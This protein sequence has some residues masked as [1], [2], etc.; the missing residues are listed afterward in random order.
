MVTEELPIFGSKKVTDKF[1]RTVFGPVFSHSGVV[2]CNCDNCLQK[3][4]NRINDDPDA[5][6]LLGKKQVHLLSKPPRVLKRALNALTKHFEQESAHLN[7]D[8]WTEMFLRALDPHAKLSERKRAITEIFETCA[9][10]IVGTFMRFISHVSTKFKKEEI[11]KPGKYPRSIADLTCVG[12]I[13]GAYAASVL[14]HMLASFFYDH[15]RKV[16]YIESSSFDRLKHAF[17]NLLNPVKSYFCYFSDDSCLSAR[18]LDGLFI[19]NMDIS[20]CD[21]SHTYLLFLT[22]LS[23]IKHPILRL[24]FEGLVDQLRCPVKV[25]NADGQTLYE[26]DHNPDSVYSITLFSGST[27]TTLVNNLA[28]FIMGVM[29][30]NLPC[31]SMT[32][33]EYEIAVLKICR[34]CGYKVTL[35]VCERPEQLQFLKHS[36]NREYE[37]CLNL[38]VLFRAFGQCRYN[39]PVYKKISLRLKAFI[40][41]SSLLQTFAHTGKNI[42]YDLLAEKYNHRDTI[43]LVKILSLFYSC[44]DGESYFDRTCIM[45]RYGLLDWEIDELT[46]YISIADF[47]SVISCSAINKIYK[48][49]YGYA[50]PTVHFESLP[51]TGN[52]WSAG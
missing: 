10:N 9:F 46:E 33:E 30:S 51:V 52:C 7:G 26:L 24:I 19:A 18:C 50:T 11:A 38:G 44:Q 34:Q 8:T 37:P 15:S 31:H 2:Y 6:H 28:N 32:R 27:L 40:F 21:S 47:G 4:L 35:D 23:L 13:L 42:F 16:E 43:D 36:P 45:S 12:S 29:I 49:D 14:K 20:S 48:I 1:Y 22:L 3:A 39:I 41:N 25:K 17:T 5:E